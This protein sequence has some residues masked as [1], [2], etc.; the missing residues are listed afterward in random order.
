MRPSDALRRRFALLL[1]IV[2]LIAIA[3]RTDAQSILAGPW[4]LVATPPTLSSISS[5]D[6]SGGP[7]VITGAGFKSGARVWCNAGNNL[8]PKPIGFVPVSFINGG[9]TQ[10]VANLGGAGAQSQAPFTAG[11][12]NCEVLNPD[13]GRASA[14]GQ[15]GLVIANTSLPTT[16]LSGLR[17]WYRS[18]DVTC[19][20]T[21]CTDGATT[22]DKW[23]DKSGNGWDLTASG[24][25]RGTYHATS[26][27][28][29]NGVPCFGS[30]PTIECNGTTNK[31]S[32]A[33]GTNGSTTSAAMWVVYRLTSSSVN[34]VISYRIGGAT[35]PVF[36]ITAGATKPAASW[37]G[38]NAT[39]N[40]A[41]AVGNPLQV[42]GWVVGGTSVNSST[43]ASNPFVTTAAATAIPATGTDT[44]SICVDLSGSV[45]VPVESV[46]V[47]ESNDAYDATKWQCMAE[48]FSLRYALPQPVTVA[49]TTVNPGQNTFVRFHGS[50][51]GQFV[52]GM[53]FSSSD[54]GIASTAVTVNDAM[55]AEVTLPAFTA[56]TGSYSFELTNPDGASVSA[57]HILKV[58]NS[59]RTPLTCAGS[60][61]AAWFDG[62]DTSEMTCDTAGCPN[63][64]HASAITDR[65][66]DDY[67]MG[68]ASSGAEPLLNVPDANFGTGHNGFTFDGAARFFRI[69]PLTHTGAAP[70]G[71]TLLAHLNTAGST[72]TALQHN[73]SFAINY[74]T[75]NGK[76]TLSAAG[77]V[78]TWS[79]ATTALVTR[80]VY[81]SMASGATP[82]LAVNVSNGTANTLTA[83]G[84]AAAPVEISLGAGV[85]GTNFWN[86]D[87]A[88]LVMYNNTLTSGEQSCI[89]TWAQ[90]YGAQSIASWIPANDNARA[91][92]ARQGWALGA[93]ALAG[94]LARRRRSAEKK[95]RAA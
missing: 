20:G 74:N 29:C 37:N 40:T 80:N 27:G 26:I 68:T 63:G 83:A 76:P 65:S 54:L 34:T 49:T 57:N 86:G 16:C 60:K 32:S 43:D 58:D 6:T 70:I 53:T 95:G 3:A 21:T 17:R 93:I 92:F 23:T 66:Y 51:A 81:V 59:I 78:L 44:F 9:G 77:S 13:G 56:S 73:S 24:T 7:V 72:V 28:T 45:F 1:G 90:S 12:Y 42:A 62:D 85:S 88:Q 75:V 48:Y 84:S 2:A 11:T 39:S 89:E 41:V 14:I 67:D 55:S 22:V 94:A 50:S 19:A 18:T 52:T 64:T 38:V 33:A 8:I 5:Q 87:V 35:N 61:V 91:A 36:S 71:D 79:G 15:A 82:A 4:S 69:S 31:F 47:V 46:E 25:A 10:I 30:Q